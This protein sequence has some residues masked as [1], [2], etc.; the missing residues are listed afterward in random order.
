MS[1]DCLLASMISDEDPLYVM[2]HFSCF[3]QDPLFVFVFL[4]LDYDVSFYRSIWIYLTVCWASRMCRLMLF[5]KFQKFGTVISSN[6]LS[7]PF[8]L[9]SPETLMY[10][11]IF[12]CIHRFLRHCS[13]ID[14]FFSFLLLG[15]NNI[16]GLIFKFIFFWSSNLFL[17]ISSE[18]L[19]FSYYIFK[20][21]DV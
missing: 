10:V 21:H 3:F 2:S 8:S 4:K 12:D 6:V 9:L 14:F 5:I 20:L 19:C 17:S 18:L 7:S 15:L 1:S 11:H 13:F 16:N